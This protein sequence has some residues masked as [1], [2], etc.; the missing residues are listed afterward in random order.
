MIDHAQPP[1]VY[2][3]GLAARSARIVTHRYLIKNAQTDS[4]LLM[5]EIGL[6]R[7]SKNGTSVFKVPILTDLTNLLVIF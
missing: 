6:A 7:V 1:I 2:V 4:I 3:S 5:S